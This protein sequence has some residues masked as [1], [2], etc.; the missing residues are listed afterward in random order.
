MSNLDKLQSCPLF[1]PL[2]VADRTLLF[3]VLKP[4]EIQDGEIVFYENSAMDR[5]YFLIQGCVK[6]YKVNRFHR[7]IFLFRQRNSGLITLY[8]P[9][10]DQSLRHYFSNVESVGTSFVT[11]VERARLDELCI[12]E[13]AIGTFMFQMFAERFALLQSIITRDLIFD[14]VAK[15]ASTLETRLDDFR[16]YKKQEIAYMLNIQP[17]TLSRILAKFK[18]EGIMEEKSGKITVKDHA[19]LNK[20]FEQ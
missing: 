17:E 12:K 13:R 19:A 8:T 4:K 18:S 6:S 3:Q 20:Y 15:V 10:S 9:F 5:V 2:S 1:L 11:Y 14:S 7:E 16:L